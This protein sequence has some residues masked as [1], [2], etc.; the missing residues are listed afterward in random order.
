VWAFAGSKKNQQWVWLSWSYQTAQVLSFAVDP[1]DG[2][3]AKKMREN[4]PVEYRKKQFCTD[5]LN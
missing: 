1:R 3:T 4:I 2:A 5:D